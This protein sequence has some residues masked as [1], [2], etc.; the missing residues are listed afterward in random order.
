MRSEA[1]VTKAIPTKVCMYEVTKSPKADSKGCFQ[2]SM[3]YYYRGDSI[4]R[5]LQ[6]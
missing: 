3:Y 2:D 1:Q 4:E 6:A 5:G